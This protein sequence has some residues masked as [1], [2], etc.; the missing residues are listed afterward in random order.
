M[1]EDDR[2]NGAASS[3]GNEPSA[4]GQLASILVLLE[5]SVRAKDTKMIVGRLM[6]QTAAIR[7]RL[8]AEVLTSFIGEALPAGHSTRVFLIAQVRKVRKCLDSCRPEE[9]SIS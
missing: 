6:R 2:R 8:D 5:K 1:K 4:S 7:S 3:P 9:P